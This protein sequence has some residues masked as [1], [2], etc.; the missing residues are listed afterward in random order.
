V[1]AFKSIK[2]RVWKRLQDYKLKFLT[3]TS[4]EILLNAVIQAIPTNS[5]SVFLLPKTLCLEINV[6]MQ[7]L[8]WVHQ[9]KSRV[10]WM[11]WSRL[12]IAKMDCGMGYRDF[13]C[14]NKALL[15]K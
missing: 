14:F 2:D 9:N 8:W 12:G 6:L 7:K 4:K 13:G 5:M 1:A 11:S 10:H 15:V 3:Q